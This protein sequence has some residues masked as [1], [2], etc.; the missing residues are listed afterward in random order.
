ML[1]LA[2][3][4][5]NPADTEL[6]RAANAH[7][8]C[9]FVID[10]FFNAA[11]ALDSLDRKSVTQWPDLLLFDLNMPLLDGRG[12]LSLRSTDPRLMRLPF[13]VHSSSNRPKDFTDCRDLGA[14][15]YVIKPVDWAGTQ[16]LVGDLARFAS[17]GIPLPD[18]G[19]GVRFHDRQADAWRRWVRA[20]R[21]TDESWRRIASTLD[22]IS[23]TL[24]P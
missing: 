4:D 7:G 6:I 3:I 16:K 1:S 24:P 23:R 22:A 21:A 20:R 14:D 11:Q 8:R 9:G 5:D 17:D 10:T 19:D 13:I 12:L 18:P 2:V 15:G